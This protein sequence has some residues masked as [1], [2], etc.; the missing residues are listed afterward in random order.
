MELHEHATG[1]TIFPSSDHFPLGQP[2][3]WVD[4]TAS[5]ASP[6]RPF[7]LSLA[8]QTRASLLDMDALGY[9]TDQQIGLILDGEDMV[10]LSRHT[11]GQTNTQTNSDGHGGVDSDTDQR[12]D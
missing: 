12:E 11:D 3:G 2:F 6:A 1:V 4:T 9:D 5:P 7:G 8:V 10:P